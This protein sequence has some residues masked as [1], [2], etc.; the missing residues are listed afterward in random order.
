MFGLVV[1]QLL[2]QPECQVCVIAAN[3]ELSMQL[4]APVGVFE[5]LGAAEVTCESLEGRSHC[6]ESFSACTALL[7]S[8]ALPFGRPPPIWWELGGQ[9]C[10]LF[11]LFMRVGTSFTYTWDV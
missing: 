9:L 6:G 10:S 8:T 7:A 1:G 2:V 5:P 11:L 4:H 3:A